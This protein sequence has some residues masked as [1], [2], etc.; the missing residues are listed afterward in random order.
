[1]GVSTNAQWVVSVDLLVETGCTA[2]SARAE[3]V[4]KTSLYYYTNLMA[5]FQD[6]LG[7]PAPERQNHS[8][9]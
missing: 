9:F 8:G 1:L 4:E 2:P 3:M 6:N 7:K 5:F